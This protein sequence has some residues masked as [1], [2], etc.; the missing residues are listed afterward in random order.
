[1]NNEQLVAR[2][3]WFYSLEINQVDLYKTQSRNFANLYPGLIFE[4]VSAIEQG[5]ADNIRDIIKN[6]GKNPTK[7]GE[8]ISP[9]IGTIGGAVIGLAGIN[10]VLEA[11]IAIEKKA[12]NDYR[13]LIETLENDE[14]PDK[15]L[16][17]L[18]KFNF[19]DE[20]LHV[21]LFQ[22]QLADLN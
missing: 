22:T 10:K 5:H 12:M 1:M 14:Y 6:F 13:N 20:H 21:A 9:V 16:I 17:K 2:L 19:I 11:N 4:R 7:L 8:V 18:L 15:D 3:N